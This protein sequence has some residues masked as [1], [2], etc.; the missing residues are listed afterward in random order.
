MISLSAG[1]VLDAE[2]GDVL[3][4]AAAAGYG[5]AGLRLDP[6]HISAGDAAR[7]RNLADDLGIALLDLEVVRLGPRSDPEQER[8]LVELAAAL[9]V[10]FL[11]TV[12]EH[13]SE[14]KSA[15]AL[16]RLTGLADTAG[17]RVALE[18]MRFTGVR[19]LDSALR[20][21]A[22]TTAAI[23]IDA[24]HLHRGGASPADLAGVPHEHMAYVQLC[25]AP[26]ER[27]GD[28]ASLAHEARHSR[29]VP[30]DGQLP[31]GQLL[32]AVPADVPV[33]IEVQSD[34]LSSRLTPADR[35]AHLLDRTRAFL[36]DGLP[37][38][39]PSHPTH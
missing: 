15:D 12:S 37:P 21:V 7:L 33:T 32:S 29:L 36:S 2:P 5:A 39:H 17:V 9:G 16:G 35:A 23:V 6:D 1:S 26:L 20:L 31:L 25:D 3:R 14:T 34:D 8:R 30:G 13:E 10:Q 28:P 24:L 11:L 22:G 27:P 4:A 19:T 38:A 18:F